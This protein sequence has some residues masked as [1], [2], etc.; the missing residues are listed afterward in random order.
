MTSTSS[1]QITRLKQVTSGYLRD[2]VE[3]EKVSAAEK[4]PC[5]ISA[6]DDLQYLMVQGRSVLESEVLHAQGIP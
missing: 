6:L 3:T 4:L 2:R 1:E 5:S